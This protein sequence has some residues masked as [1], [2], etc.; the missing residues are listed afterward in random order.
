MDGHV[1]E[2]EAMNLAP[3]GK[4]KGNSKLRKQI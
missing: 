4:E 2:G 1:R 3:K